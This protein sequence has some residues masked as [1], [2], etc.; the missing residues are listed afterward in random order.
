VWEDPAGLNYLTQYSY[1][2][3]N[4]VT[5]I[6]QDVQ[7][8]TFTYDGLSRL[9]TARIPEQVDTSTP[10]IQLP[11]TYT[12]DENGNLLSKTFTKGGVSV[13]AS[14]G[15][16]V[17][18]RITSVGYTDGTPD[19]SYT[20]DN[21]NIS[22]GKGLPYQVVA[23]YSAFAGGPISYTATGYDAMGRL[24]EEKTGIRGV[25]FT[26]GYAYDLAGNLTSLTYP[27]NKRVTYTYTAA[28]R[29][30][31]VGQ[32]AQTDYYFR[33]IGYLPHG[34]VSSLQYGNGLT[35]TRTYD[36]VR[37]QLTTQV[38][39]GSVSGGLM[40]L[41]YQYGAE[42]NPPC[43]TSAYSRNNGNLY[44]IIDGTPRALNYSF[45]Y[46]ALNR[47]KTAQIVGQTLQ[48]YYYDRFGNMKK[49]DPNVAGFIN[50][51]TNRIAVTPYSY[52][53]AGNLLNDG[54]HTYSYDA[55]NRMTQIDNGVAKYRYDGQGRRAE[56]ETGL[57][58]TFYLYEQSGNLISEYQAAVGSLV[59]TDLV[60]ST[61]VQPKYYH[62]DQL[63]SV[64]IVTDR[65]G[66]VVT[67]SQRDFYPY[68]EEIQQPPTASNQPK[69]AGYY[70]DQETGLDHTWFRKYSPVLGR[71][72]S[73]D[74][75]S[76]SIANPQ[77]LNKYAFVANNPL[78]YADANGKE[79]EAVV[80]KT[81]A[82]DSKLGYMDSR[83]VNDFDNFV[84][85][86]KG[87]G[88]APTFTF[89]FRTTQEQ[90]DLYDNRA[91]N[92]NPVAT[93]GTSA[94]ESGLAFDINQ[95]ALRQQGLSLADIRGL[96]S[97]SGFEPLPSGKDPPHL[98]FTGITTIS[99][100]NSVFLALIKE[101]QASYK[102][103]TAL[104]NEL[105]K[106]HPIPR[107]RNRAL[108]RELQ[109]LVL[110]I[111]ASEINF[112]DRLNR[113]GFHGEMCDKYGRDRLGW[114][115]REYGSASASGYSPIY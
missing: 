26:T 33:N 88:Y 61:T 29:V 36:P 56:K 57:T 47:M 30:R 32:E 7:T 60:C 3:L 23:N 104:Y 107:L 96:A 20:Y 1:D 40:N 54:S 72:M 100:R 28:N 98:Q 94:H 38:I 62:T 112:L 82:G 37:L 55:E 99:G 2:A 6:T 41:T 49:N 70:R 25:N 18:N 76:G 45:C 52:D 51:L 12:Y 19:V 78:K 73:L 46:D 4:N 64:R 50:P 34:G 65:I 9:K 22:N 92:S 86:L 83:A 39:P 91:A 58:W 16:D 17:I 44:Q 63:G 106:G 101:N 102:R 27:S 67:G 74:I 13:T 42:Q 31:M 71:W 77:S 85:T 111:R 5:T 66:Q 84:E 108:D 81:P 11:T 35:E 87:L 97:E 21:T 115:R 75:H 15:Y 89:L 95:L 93:P 69:F 53:E 90:Q 79:L 109:L 113:C 105:Y 14:Y 59:S 110:N 114:W 68:G 10:P 103:L 48:N 43:G 8:R 80:Y 24:L